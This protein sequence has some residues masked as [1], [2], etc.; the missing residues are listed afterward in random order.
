MI[1]SLTKTYIVLVNVARCCRN[2]VLLLYAKIP[3]LFCD[4]RLPC[5]ISCLVIKVDFMV[6]S[7]SMFCC[8]YAR[9]L[10]NLSIRERFRIFIMNPGRASSIFNIKGKWQYIFLSAYL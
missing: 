9:V 4:D 2:L 7:P 6:M 5:L 8:L 3:V 1:V 10:I